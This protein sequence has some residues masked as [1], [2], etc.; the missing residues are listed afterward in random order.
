MRIFLSYSSRDRSLAESVCASLRAQ[1]H[2]VFFDRSDL[3]SGEEYDGRIRRAIERSHLFVFLVSPHALRDESYARTELA[4]AQRTR[5]NPA[6]RVLPVLVAPV[7]L[8]RIPPYLRS[9]TLLEP[10]GHVPAAVTD[11]VHRLAHDRRRRVLARAAAIALAALVVLGAYAYRGGGDRTVVTGRDGAR[12]LL[13]PA[14]TFTMGDDEE[15]PLREVFVSAFYIDEHEV[16]VGRYARFIEATGAVA[17][18]DG[19]QSERDSDPGTLPV[20]GIDWHDADA[21]CRWAGRRLPTDAEWE[22]AAR[23]PDGRPYPW[24]DAAPAPRHAHFGRPFEADAYEA[25]LAPV[26]SYPDGRSPYGVHDL[27]GNASEWVA[28]WHTDSY[29]RGDV[30]DPT[31]PAEGTAK[32]IRGGGWYDPPERLK[33]SRRMFAEP[34]HFSDDIGFRCARDR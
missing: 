14:G 29:V 16:T 34:R 13:V 8:E 21:Y 23:G 2:Q 11:A 22:K 18:P 12:A 25:G 24:G 31:G 20:V 3:P 5:P 32:V 17:L 7:E 26:G 30:P 1:R 33:A 4:I 10:A 27:A 6:G 19:W 15:A 9:V 28:D